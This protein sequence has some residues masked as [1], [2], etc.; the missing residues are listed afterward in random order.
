MKTL[1][2]PWKH[3]IESIGDKQKGVASILPSKQ[4]KSHIWLDK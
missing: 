1:A 3:Y 2:Q 4:R